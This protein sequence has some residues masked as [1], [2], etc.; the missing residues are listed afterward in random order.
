M[1]AAHRFAVFVRDGKPCDTC[2][3]IMQRA[4]AGSRRIYFCA[5]YQS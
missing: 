2:G 4:D 5:D 3:A 1:R